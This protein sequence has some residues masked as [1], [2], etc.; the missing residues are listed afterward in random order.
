MICYIN[1]YL[2]GFDKARAVGSHPNLLMCGKIDV[3][4]N[5]S[6]SQEIIVFKNSSNH[7]SIY[8]PRFIFLQQRNSVNLPWQLHRIHHTKKMLPEMYTYKKAPPKASDL[9]WVSQGFGWQLLIEWPSTLA[10]EFLGLWSDFSKSDISVFAICPGD[11]ITWPC[12]K[13]IWPAVM[14]LYFQKFSLL[15]L[16][17]P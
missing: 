1:D 8:F 6:L 4:Q 3:T 17:L 13:I 15:S 16:I 5:K 12:R 2:L 9:K 7:N 14:K 11:S 10:G